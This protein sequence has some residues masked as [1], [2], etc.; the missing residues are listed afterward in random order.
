MYSEITELD[1][2]DLSTE[3]LVG[4]AEIAE[5]VGGKTEFFCVRTGVRWRWRE[6]EERLRWKASL[7]G[8]DGGGFEGFVTQ[9]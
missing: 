3:T 5:R 2:L 7:A 8:E 6:R 4:L 9:E 1:L